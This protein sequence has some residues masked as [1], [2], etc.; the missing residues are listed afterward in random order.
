[1][2]NQPTSKLKG[3]TLAVSLLALAFNASA[4]TAPTIQECA[5]CSI[6]DA[7]VSAVNGKIDFHYGS[8]NDTYTRGVGGALSLPVGKSFGVQIDGLYARAAETDIYGYGAHFFTRRPSKGLLGLAAGGL[9]STDFND[10]VVGV[11]G[12]YYLDKITLGAF[13]GYNNFDSHF[14][15]PKL[16][17]RLANETNFVAAR[18]Y[19]AIYPIDDLVI[20]IG[21]E[22]RFERNFYTA[23]LEYQTPIA[24]LALFADGALGDASFYSLVGGVR[25]Y[26]G[27][28]KSLKARH[29]QDDP[30]SLPGSN[31]ATSIAGGQGGSAA[32]AATKE[33]PPS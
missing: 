9:T 12:E 15:N 30:Q 3:C 14:T 32:P 33:V 27:A 28:K 4:G 24:G 19:A 26:F 8:V 2:R 7:A 1:M 21:Y 18:L 25:Y 5:T 20:R 29:R 17:G 16:G 13:V 31:L 11:E 22:N 6:T 23:H 10:F